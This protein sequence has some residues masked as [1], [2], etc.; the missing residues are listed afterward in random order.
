MPNWTTNILKCSVRDSKLFLNE[1]GTVDF[2]K[3]IPM[4]ETMEVEFIEN[5]GEKTL[6]SGNHNDAGIDILYFL[7]ERNTH[8]F[9]LMSVM[10]VRKAFI[11]DSIYNEFSVNELIAQCIESLKEMVA[12]Y[13]TASDDIKDEAYI[14]GSKWFVNLKDWGVY[15]W[16]DWSCA[17]WGTKWN[18]CSVEVSDVKDDYVTIMFATAWSMPNPTM[19]K[20]VFRTFKDSY[21]FESADED[22]NGVHDENY[23][24]IEEPELFEII[25]ETD[26]E[27]EGHSYIYACPL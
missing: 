27:D 24:E 9:D 20:D 16:Y 5:K 22:F 18:A 12:R 21:V 6:V 8:P 17:Y 3:F 2:N 23:T 10:P 11:K 14:R 1:E 13:D 26:E 25:E 15:D 7:T 19:L 4:P